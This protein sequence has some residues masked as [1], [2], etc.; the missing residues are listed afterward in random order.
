MELKRIRSRSKILLFISMLM[1]MVLVIAYAKLEWRLPGAPMDTTDVLRGRILSEDGTI[2]AQSVHDPATGLQKRIYPQKTLAGALL[3]V[4]GTDRGLSG[5]ELFY[6]EEL[7]SGRD[8]IVTLD[9]SIQTVLESQMNRYATENQGVYGSAVILDTPTGKILA[10][11]S[12]PTFDPNNW[13]NYPT[14]RWRNRPFVDSYEPGSVIKALVVAGILNDGKTHPEQTFDTPMW[15]AIGNNRIRDAVQHPPRL[16]TR[17]ILRYSSNVGM[18]HLVQNYPDQ[19]LYDYLKQYGFGEATPIENLYTED[20]VV[21]P[22]SRWSDIMKVN[23]SF[24]QG[25]TTNTVQVAAAYNTLAND[26]QYTAPYLV[27]VDRI[28]EERQVLTETTA[29]TMRDLLRRVV[30]DGIKTAAGIPGYDIGGKSS[31]AQVVVNGRYSNEI[32]NSLFAGFFPANQPKVTMVIMVHGAKKNYF[33]SMLAAPI[34][35][36]V[37]SEMVS[38]WG[39]PP[40]W[41]RLQEKAKP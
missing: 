38:Q 27:A 15:R 14:E 19:S 26:G 11:A 9:P 2:L 16:T 24:G 7:A 39:F 30:D 17:E 29:R 40:D 31:T 1:F 5:L 25:M 32:Y 37:A 35:R 6:Q 28:R 3:G 36:D 20:G 13:R 8:V 22:P 23:M 10:A 41:K 33:G 12:W 4:L 21:Y 34:F 18:S